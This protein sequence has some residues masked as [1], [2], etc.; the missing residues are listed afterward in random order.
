M[1][2]SITAALAFSTFLSGAAMG[3]CQLP[4]QLTNGQ[5]ADATQ[6][7]SNF[8]ALA[9]CVD[10]V[11]PAGSANSIQYNNG[12][13]GF[14]GVAPLADGQLVIGSTDNP[15]QAGTI[16]AGAGIAVLTSPGNI[17]IAAT[18]GGSG[19]GVDWLNQAALVKPVAANFTLQTST[20]AP[21]GAALTPTA[22][23]LALTATAATASTA[24]MAEVNLPSGNW[25]ATMLATYT[26][27][28]GTY[29]VPGIGVRDAVTNRTVIFGI[30]GSG[31]TAFRFDYEM[32]SGGVGLNTY[33]ND[34]SFTEGGLPAPSAA[35][36]W[37]RLTFDG[38][39]FVWSF[40][41]DGQ[42]F[43]TAYTVSATSYITNRSKIGPVVTFQQTQR[44]TWSTAYHVLSWN[45]QSI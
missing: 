14:A 2:K 3:A 21:A 25:Q 41:R 35:P 22:R 45:L 19:G 34:V 10:T 36:L 8:T 20:S 24:M 23:G 6:V 4:N 38:T 18:G 42:F 11:S 31:G 33:S 29:N 39:N 43:I 9:D 1:I 40:S 16:T 44:P 27:P 5:V 12:S 7:M 17:T 28:L 26:G 37:S 30:G 15:P 13:G 32:F